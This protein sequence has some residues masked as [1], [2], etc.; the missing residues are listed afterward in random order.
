MTTAD[1][2]D[3]IAER[4]AASPVRDNAAY[5]RTIERTLAHLPAGANVVELG[6]GTGTTALRLAPSLGK[7]LATDISAEMIRIA[8]GRRAEA[9][10]SAV[11]VDF[12]VRDVEAALRDVQRPDAVLAFNLLHLLPDLS[13]DLS[14]IA[15]SLPPGGHFISKSV[16]L[17]DAGPLMRL[18]LMVALPLMRLVGRAPRVAFLTR[19]ALEDAVAEAGFEIIETADLPASPPNRFIVAR[20]RLADGHERSGIDGPCDP[21]HTTLH[22][23]P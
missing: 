13:R 11:N 8:E 17:A 19:Q 4:Y 21:R 14:R 3:R 23:L 16:C 20:R 7:V 22:L 9:E 6:C 2:W 15:A 10:T 5:D 18:A 1:F 12:A